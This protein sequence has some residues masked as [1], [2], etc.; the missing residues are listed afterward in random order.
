MLILPE[1]IA[2]LK[3]EREEIL[4]NVSSEERGIFLE[5]RIPSGWSPKNQKVKRLRRIHVA[6]QKLSA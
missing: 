6:I 3:K 1:V 5:G 2:R 4:R